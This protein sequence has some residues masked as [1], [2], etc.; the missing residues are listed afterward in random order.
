MVSPVMDLSD[1]EWNRRCVA[2]CRWL[3]A[4]GDIGVRELAAIAGVPGYVVCFAQGMVIAEKE[5]GDLRATLRALVDAV[6]VE[7]LGDTD[8]EDDGTNVFAAF[9][10]AVDLLA[11]EPSEAESP[12]TKTVPN[13]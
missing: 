12:A 13:G 5:A 1:K 7:V 4:E 3:K 2:A 10:R 8:L 6:D 11:T 9:R